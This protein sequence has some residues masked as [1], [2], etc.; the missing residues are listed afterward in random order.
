MLSTIYIH[1]DWLHIRVADIG[2]NNIKC[3]VPYEEDDGIHYQI[4]YV[5]PKQS[6]AAA[7]FL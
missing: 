6:S 5:E 4:T 3:I 2:A 7:M 1:S